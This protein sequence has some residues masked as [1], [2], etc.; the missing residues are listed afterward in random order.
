MKKEIREA[1]KRIR[2]AQDTLYDCKYDGI[3][4]NVTLEMAIIIRDAKWKDR[5][6]LVRA[7]R[8]GE[9]HYVDAYLYQGYGKE[10]IEKALEPIKRII[11]WL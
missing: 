10:E 9:P 7:A 4:S 3:M 8:Q 11:T 1:V 2:K 5:T 6:I